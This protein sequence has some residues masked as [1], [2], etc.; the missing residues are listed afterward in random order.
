M[1]EKLTEELLDELLFTGEIEEYLDQN[2]I[3]E[4]QKLSDYLSDLLNEKNLKKNEII[5]KAKLNTTFGYQIF[6]GE[7]NPGRDKIL[8]LTFAM[9]LSL[10]ETQRALKHG[11]VN[12]LYPK[13]RR[14]AIIIH[15]IENKA[16]L[17]ETDDQL[18]KFGED[19]ICED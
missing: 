17:E 5:R 3:S 9:N 18:F 1:T 10:R 16:G 11:G 4:I 12:E 2:D 14:D 8:Q 6:A 19:T 7:R 15:C 13:D